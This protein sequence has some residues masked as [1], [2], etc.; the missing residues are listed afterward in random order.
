VQTFINKKT[1][2]EYE[3]LYIAKDATNSRSGVRVVMYRPLNEP[4]NV[5]VRDEEEF[6][7]KFSLGSQTW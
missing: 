2:Q 6:R 3:V 4:N 1:L 7:E 5:Y